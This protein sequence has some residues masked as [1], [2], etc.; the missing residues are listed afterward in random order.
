V[1]LGAEAVEALENGVQLAVIEML[2]VGHS[3]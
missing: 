3:D 2:A 1:H